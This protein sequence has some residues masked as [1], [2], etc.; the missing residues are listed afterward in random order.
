MKKS[1]KKSAQEIQDDIF[2]RM[3]AQKKMLLGSQ[4]WQ[5]AKTLVGDKVNY[6]PPRSFGIIDG[7]RKNP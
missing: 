4:L 2:R 3:S 1:K 6:V 7:H 5:L